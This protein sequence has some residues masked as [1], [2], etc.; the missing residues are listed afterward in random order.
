M[1]NSISINSIN[2][3]S[4]SG[5]LAGSNKLYVPV[6]PA[7]VIY[8]QFDHVAGYAARPNQA[9]VSVSKVQILNS[10]IDQLA[11]MKG[12]PKLDV[13]SQQLSEKQIDGLIDTLQTKLQTTMQ[14][15]EA[16]GYGLAGVAPEAGMLFSVVA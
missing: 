15:A 12:T 5:V 11:T 2:S 13:K 1:V 6:K 8:S 9:G 14:V 16:T 7:M 3:Y 4:I 10:L